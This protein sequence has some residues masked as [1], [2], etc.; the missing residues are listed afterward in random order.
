[1]L[2]RLAIRRATLARLLRGSL[3]AAATVAAPTHAQT[4]NN[5]PGAAARLAEA[6]Q[7]RP[8]TNRTLSAEAR[9][10]LLLKA[11]T[12]DEKLQLTFGYFSTTADWQ[13]TAVKNW[14]MP[15]DGL[16]DSAGFVPGIPRLG[17]PG[18][19]QTDAGLGVASQRTQ[20]P[21]LRTALPSGIATA[22]TWNP[23]LAQAGGAMIGNEAFLS[24]FNVQLAGGMNLMREPRN[25]RNFEYSG[26]DPLLSG[27]MTGRQIKGIQSQNIVST[28]KHFAFNAQE[29]NRFTI[30]HRIA[31]KAARQSDLLAFEIAL[32]VGDPGSVM[33]AYN[34]VNG[35]YACENDWLL[36][37]TLK[38]DWG[39]KGYVMSDWGAT[40]STTQAANAGLDQQSGWAF[41]RSAYFSDALREAVN[42]GYVSEARATDMARRILWAMF[43]N[44]LFDKPVTGDRAAS[45]DYKAHSVVTRADAEE[46]IVLLKNSR[47]LLPLSR[48][49]KSI[50]LVGAHAD[51]GVLSGGGSSQVYPHGGPVNGLTVPDGYPS[52]FPG[53]KL[54]YPSSPMKALQARTGAVVTYLDGKDVKAAVAAARSSEIVVVFGEQWTGESID[55]PDLALPDGQDQLIDAVARANPRTV[56]VLQTG[57]PVLMPWLNR[58][59]AV[60]EAWYPGTSGGDAIARVLTG[61]VNPSGHLP[62]TFPA[63]LAQLPR[64]AI[65]GDPKLDRD[66]HPASNLDIEGA[67]I[68]Y[69]WF[70][71]RGMTPMFPFG[72]GLSYTDFRF[73]KLSAVRLSKSVQARFTVTNTGGVRGKAV[74][75]LYIAGAGWEAP[76][77]L[78]GFEKVDLGPGEMREVTLT[79]DP[80]LLATFDTATRGWR[81]AEGRY[82]MLLATTANDVVSRVSIN[83]DAATLDSHGR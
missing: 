22:A 64:A 32:E 52:G 75:Q 42:N 56:I 55:V 20:T 9:A 74:P 15:K 83:L 19:W 41:D 67:A 7:K 33:C 47:G 62:A 66:A 13:K 39:F 23:D 65:E 27:I 25:G 82:E 50:L 72:H 17:V 29:T 26:E 70:D 37:R 59:G 43:R 51:I 76:K 10:D 6:P 68:G 81:I 5:A 12:L 78:A 1:M 16:P 36:N 2:N 53:P 46:G 79:V 48:T 63:S 14:Q 4:T 57:G 31:E 40:H 58:V 80:R 34:R 21:R 49:A 73:G 35:Y 30:D 11:M 44:G 24:G 38:R 54:Y 61:E 28:M 60:L 45:I 18:Q 3:M 77:R 71:R 69:K 8:W